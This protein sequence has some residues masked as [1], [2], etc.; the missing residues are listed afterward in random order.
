MISNFIEFIKT[1]AI[2]EASIHGNIGIPGEKDGS[3]NYIN[4]IS[5]EED[6]K[7]KVLADKYGR[8]PIA[9][10]MGSVNKVG[11]IQSGHEKKLA[12]LAEKTIYAYYG[13]ILDQVELDIK[14]STPNVIKDMMEEA[15]TEPAEVNLDL[16]KDKKIIDEI[17]KRKILNNI[18]QGEAKN[19]KKILNMPESVDG[20][21]RILGEEEGME[22]LK[23][24]NII[25]DIAGYFDWNIPAEAQREM[26]KRRDAF[27]GSVKTEWKPKEKKE[28]DDDDYVKKLLDELSKKSE[29]PDEAENLFN[30]ITP[31]I[32]A[33]GTDY[34]ML[35]HE[36][37]KGIYELISMGGYPSEEES[38]PEEKEMIE[39]VFMNTDTLMDEIEDLKYGPG[40]AKDLRDFLNNYPSH[41]EIENF[42]EKVYGKMVVMEADKFLSLM[43][44]ILGDEPGAKL[45]V[46]KLVEEVIDEDLEYKR[47]ISKDTVYEPSKK[48]VSK[49]S[50]KD[51]LGEIDA[52]L[53][54]RNFKEVEKLSKELENLKES[55]TA[56]DI[57]KL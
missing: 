15:P 2:Q 21:K 44:M 9:T 39:T 35:I 11:S 5:K 30:D 17:H 10:F 12:D 23:H 49:R 13:S 46:D 42:R 47:A 29:V 38:T 50:S 19:V 32:I 51:I 18:T 14:F 48:S 7:S 16:L 40:I 43:C 31:K 25:C 34:S 6:D 56:E 36:T 28:D 57:T 54:A 52:A 45:I 1:R 4:K 8:N 27:S 20:F 41:T 33:R 22:Y 24:L 26:W 53:D 55:L 3:K 37:V